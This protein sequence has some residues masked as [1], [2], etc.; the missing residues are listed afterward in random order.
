MQKEFLIND[1]SLKAELNKES[2]GALTV[3]VG[4][5]SLTATLIAKTADTVILEVDGR[6]HHIY[7]S[8]PYFSLDNRTLKVSSAR[9]AKKK[10]GGGAGS[11][12]MSSPMPGKI[13]KVLVSEGDSVEEGQGLVV[14]EA[15]KMEHTIKAAYPGTIQKIHYAEG[16]LVDGGVDLVDLA[17]NG[18]GDS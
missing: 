12:E 2:D 15:M 6:R 7:S 4:D 14:M 17:S 9:D 18:E 1:E 13:L 16:D 3:K 5:T 10:K 8:S 11:D